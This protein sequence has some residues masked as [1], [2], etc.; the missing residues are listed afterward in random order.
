VKLDIDYIKRILSELEDSD[1]WL[2]V[3]PDDADTACS[4]VQKRVYHFLLMED[5]GLVVCL[6]PAEDRRS[7]TN[8]AFRMTFQGHEYLATIRDE[9]IW[10]DTKNLVRETGGNASLE[11]I[12]AIAVG[13]L[14]KKISQHTDI[15]L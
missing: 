4:D 11:I 12:K 6:R 14:R 5:A 2:V 9:G 3:G 7:L 15:Q 13:L 1:D 10:A 8:E